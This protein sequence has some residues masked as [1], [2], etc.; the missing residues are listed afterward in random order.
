MTQTDIFIKILLTILFGA[1]LGLET[2]TRSREL[3]GEK[4]VKAQEKSR[5]GGVRTYTVL[6][7]FGGVAGILFVLGQYVIVY[8]LFIAVI[9]LIIAAY[10]LNVQIKH[11]FG[12]TTEI[13]VIITFILGFLTTA[14][15]IPLWLILVI[16]VLLTFFLSQK[17]GIG[18]LISKIQHKEVIDVIKFAMVAVVILPVLP[19]QDFYLSDFFNAI[20]IT[21][22][23]LDFAKKIL[24]INPFNIWLIVV[25][26]SGINMFGYF[27]SRIFGKNKG[28]F[29]TAILSGFISS[30]SATVS[31]AVK[32]KIN[33]KESQD[34]AGASLISNAVSFVSLGIVA[35]ASSKS[36]FNALAPMA[37][38]MLVSGFIVGTLFIGKKVDIKNKSSLEVAYEPFSIGPAVRFVVILILIKVAIQILQLFNAGSLLL[39]VVTAITGVSGMDAPVI[40]LGGLVGSNILPLNIAVLAF[41]LTNAI[42]FLSKM[43]IGYLTG[44][45][46]F[47]KII[48]IGLLITA[49]IGLI[50]LFLQ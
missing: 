33:E 35:L 6:A 2:E 10:V 43:S 13:A 25:L 1:I 24:I 41:V 19:N 50:G 7:L 30:T 34:L 45:R 42:N 39:I 12:L 4:H 16:L 28:L 49:L 23:N 46:K 48:S 26:I 8:I 47:F 17:R 44:S 3:D 5:I 20:G 18:Q 40:A 11:L 29:M 14:S 9:L 32:S 38:L 31:F 36:F 27:L 15:L 37:V 22:L 21:N